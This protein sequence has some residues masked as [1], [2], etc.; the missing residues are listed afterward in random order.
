[1][2]EIKKESN[3]LNVLYNIGI[4][5]HEQLKHENK[6]NQL[7]GYTYKMLNS[8]KSGN[9]K[10]F[11][12]V[13]VRLHMSLQK[14]VSQIFLEIM[15]EEKLDFESIAHSFISGLISNKYEKEGNKKDE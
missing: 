9:K 1:M 13:V 12:D 7:N 5:I 6:E 3:K 2:E 15:K 10:E 4:S 14:D 11:M 8:V